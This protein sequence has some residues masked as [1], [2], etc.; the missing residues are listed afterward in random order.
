VHSRPGTPSAA[1]LPII[2]GKVC[3]RLIH[4]LFVIFET[5]LP[6]QLG[7]FPLFRVPIVILYLHEY[8]YG[9]YFQ[10]R[11]RGHRGCV[12]SETRELLLQR[13]GVVGLRL[14]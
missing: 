3:S 6:D 14:Y 11:F 10:V 12:I 1:S 8:L 13:Y 4:D 5:E 2:E 9:R 7:G